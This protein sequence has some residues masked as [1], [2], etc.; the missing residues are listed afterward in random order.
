M[1]S[2]LWDTMLHLIP[3]VSCKPASTM[4]H[5][6]DKTPSLTVFPLGLKITPLPH[7]RGGLIW[8]VTAGQLMVIVCESPPAELC[9]ID[10]WSVPPGSQYSCAVSLAAVC[11]VSWTAVILPKETNSQMITHNM[12]IR[13]VH[14]DTNR[15]PVW[16][17]TRVC[18][19]NLEHAWLC[20]DICCLCVCGDLLTSIALNY[21]SNRTKNKQH[22][23]GCNYERRV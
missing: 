22:H 4:L 6:W 19:N 15:S 23:H 10:G 12:Q 3:W 8:G 5:Y 14:R 13:S 16:S 1:Q 9:P 21:Y 20:F 18:F 11:F 7:N 17:C 2:L